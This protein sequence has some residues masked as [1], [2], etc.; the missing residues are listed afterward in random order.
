M[1]DELNS[2]VFDYIDLENLGIE[3]LIFLSYDDYFKC[4]DNQ[5]ERK[6]KN[7]FYGNSD[8]IIYLN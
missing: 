8:Y 4:I 7:P 5:L 3:W 1:D 6:R 2:Y